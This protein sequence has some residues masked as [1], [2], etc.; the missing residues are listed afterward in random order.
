MKVS[1]VIPTYKR[2]DILPR[3]IKSVLSQSYENLEVIVVSD[4][5][6]EETDKVMNQFVDNNK[7]N[8]YTYPKNQGGNYARNYGITHSTGEYI[9]FLDDDDLWD[10]DKLQKQMEI[11]KNKEIGLVYTGKKHIFT[12]KKLE[13]VS[14]A[15]VTGDLSDKIFEKN[16][17][18]STSC[19]LVEKELVIRAGLFD[20]ELPSLQDF[21]LWIRICQL[22]K[23]G[24]VNE[25]LLIYI[26]EDENNQVS[27]D[28]T[29]R[30]KAL[31][32]ITNKYADH[33]K[34][35]NELKNEL[36]KYIYQT[37]LKIAQRNTDKKSLRKYRKIYLKKYKGLKPWLFVIATSI[38]H[39]LLLK[40]RTLL[41]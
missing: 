29:K 8:Y 37:V 39:N 41:N 6:H 11:I 30:V 18:G 40:I 1:V 31:E 27:A 38:P 22:T 19:V 34:N 35:K 20:E 10:K 13:F 12:D 3:A 2:P 14:D 7:I 25:P 28:I 17:I 32:L 15:T 24:A 16:F 33:L 26:N 23:V 36:E 21:D 5:F 4:G 9:A